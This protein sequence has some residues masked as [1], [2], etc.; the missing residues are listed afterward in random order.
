VGWG[1]PP[2]RPALKTG[3]KIAQVTARITGPKPK[4][5]M[6]VSPQVQVIVEGLADMTELV[7][8]LRDEVRKILNAPEI[9]AAVS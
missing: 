7:E 8:G 1:S 6:K 3:T 4:M 2:G 5:E 9:I